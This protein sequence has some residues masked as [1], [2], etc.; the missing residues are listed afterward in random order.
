MKDW[1]QLT[2]EPIDTRQPSSFVRDALAIFKDIASAHDA[3][4]RIEAIDIDEALAAAQQRAQ[5]MKDADDRAWGVAMA[6]VMADLVQQGWTLH[7]RR[8]HLWGE[9]PLSGMSREVLRE[10]LL[11][12]RDEQLMKTS[13]RAFVRDMERWRLHKGQRTSIVSLMRDGRALAT[14]LA[15]GESLT[16]LVDP[17]IQF[18]SKDDVCAFTGLRTQDIWRYF[19]HTWSSPYES[20]PGRSLQFIVRDRAA[21]L[22]PVIGIAA[23]S[24]AAVRLGPRD[25]FIGWDTDQVVDRLIEGDRDEALRWARKVVQGAIDEIYTVDF[26]RDLLLPADQT[27]WTIETALACAQSAASAKVQHHRLMEA[28]EYKSSDDVTTEEACAARAELYLFRA[29]RAVELSKLIPLLIQLGSGLPDGP[30]GRELLSR[31]VR[32][33]RS[34]TVGTEIADLTVCGAIAPYSHLAGGK[35]VAMLATTPAVIAEYKRRYV[36]SPGIIASSMAGRPIGRPANLCYIGTTSLYGRRPNQ[37][38][39]LGM[40]AQLVGGHA[41]LTIRYEHIQDESDSRTQGVGTFHFSSRTLRGLERFVSS[42]KGGWKANNLFGEGTSPKLRGLRDGLIALGLDADELLVHGIER[43]MYGVKLAT[44]LDRYLL[45]MDE[46]P[47]WVFDPAD[48]GSDK[49]AAWWAERWAEARA[50]REDVLAKVRHE[51]LAHPIRHHARVR[52]PERED[53]QQAIF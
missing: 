40:P 42:R 19:R 11:V 32:I 16:A 35:L 8:E 44:N 13:V 3:G 31:V 18:V 51:G 38:D 2:K 23:L 30:Q 27:Q 49:V 37:Y 12:R 7:F 9:R 28:Q 46:S 10:R 4:E 17:Y 20:V 39:R 47:N 36:N 26:V 5:R 25:R 53:G 24:S 41:G 6:G 21:P 33:A 34:K 22:H 50:R 43:C 15:A 29:K 14:S 1:T 48:V 52:L 45:G